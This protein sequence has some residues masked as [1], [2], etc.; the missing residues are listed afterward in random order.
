MANCF[1]LD[2]RLSIFCCSVV[3]T[4]CL[5]TLPLSDFVNCSFIVYALSTSSFTSSANMIIHQPPYSVFSASSALFCRLESVQ[6]LYISVRI[7][8]EGSW[9][10]RYSS[11]YPTISLR[12]CSCPVSPGKNT[13]QRWYLSYHLQTVWRQFFLLLQSVSFL[14]QY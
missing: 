13:Q 7:G 14:R 5:S 12:G 9:A 11:S 6:C 2:R 10:Q 1:L 8:I 3:A 4:V